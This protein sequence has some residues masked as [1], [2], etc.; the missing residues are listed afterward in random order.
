MK[1]YMNRI[2]DGTFESAIDHVTEALKAEGF[3]VL[4]DID[5]QKTMKAKLGKDFRSYRILGACNPQLAFQALTVED[6]IGAML[7]CNVVVQQLDDGRIEVAAID[8]E[9][10]MRSVGNA[11]LSAVAAIVREKVGRVV[12]SL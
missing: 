4:T 11:D 2:I 10:S 8:P 7:P 12:A 9:A 5:V 1:F 3:G 6:K